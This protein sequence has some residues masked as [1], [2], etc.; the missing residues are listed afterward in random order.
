[1]LALGVIK[2]LSEKLMKICDRA[3]AKYSARIITNGYLLD[4]KAVKTLASLAVEEAQV[5]IDGPPEVHNLRRRLKNG[6]ETYSR[7]LANVKDAMAAIPIILRMNVDQ[8]NRDRIDEMLDILVKEGLHTK[9]GF[10]IGWTTPYTDACQDIAENCL[11]ADDFSLLGMETMMKMIARGFTSAFGIPQ[12]KDAVCLAE[13]S[14]AFVIMPRGGI[15]NCWNEIDSTDAEIGHLWKPPTP[16]MEINAR[17]WQEKNPFELECY[18]CRL[19]PICMGGC[20]YLLM[21]S[22]KLPCHPWKYNLDEGLALYFYLQVYA[23][24]AKITRAFDEAVEAAKALKAAVSSK[25]E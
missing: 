5:T 6:G 9:A 1:L 18:D 21:K 13:N 20:P 17:R 7:V 22:G 2:R 3:S 10:H 14:R 15:V 25:A 19:L 11:T 16:R 24:Q 12:R 23:R 8:T 4:K